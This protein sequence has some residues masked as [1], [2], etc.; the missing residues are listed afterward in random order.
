MSQEFNKRDFRSEEGP[1]YRKVRKRKAEE[2]EANEYRRD[3]LRLE[4]SLAT[5]QLHDLHPQLNDNTEV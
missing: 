2:Q 3:Q 4:K 5:E 1:A